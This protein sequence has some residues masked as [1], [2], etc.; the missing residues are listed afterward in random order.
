M[1]VGSPPPP[2][3]LTSRLSLES[4]Q[5]GPQLSASRLAPPKASP[6]SNPAADSLAGGP[7]ST[8]H[9]V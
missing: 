2:D 6:T 1:N 7:C 9:I 3:L 8:E 5:Q 4:P